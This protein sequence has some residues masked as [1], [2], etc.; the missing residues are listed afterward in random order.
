MSNTLSNT[1]S[2]QLELTL[3]EL[4]NGE[5]Y[6]YLLYLRNLL[7]ELVSKEEWCKTQEQINYLHNLGYVCKRFN[8]CYVITQT[9]DEELLGKGNSQEEA[10]L[11]AIQ[12]WKFLYS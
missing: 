12:T 11:N 3:S 8:G 9:Q 1:L 4:S 2:N 10:W 5:S 6:S 7:E